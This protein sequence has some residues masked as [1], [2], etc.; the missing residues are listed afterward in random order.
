MKSQLTQAEFSLKLKDVERL[1]YAT[2][3][4][5]DR[6]LIKCLYF[7]GLRR[8]EAKDLEVQD[9]DFD[10]KRIIVR[11]GKGDKTRVVP[12][13]NPEFMSDLQHHIGKRKE[14]AVFIS[15]KGNKMSNG[16]INLIVKKAG[17]KA[18][19]THPNPNMKGINPHLLRHSIAR[20]LKDMAFPAEFIQKFLGHASFKTT[21]DMYGTLSIDEM[22]SMVNRKIGYV[23]DRRMLE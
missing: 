19:L 14:G 3:N 12:I 22:Q 5:R 23:D 17:Q 11:H 20:H 16:T 9:I 15:N 7:A 2:S 4:F 18:E 13:I 6:C 1:I 8:F 10:R 21:M